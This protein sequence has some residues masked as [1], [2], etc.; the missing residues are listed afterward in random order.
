MDKVKQKKK[1]KKKKGPLGVYCYSI[2]KPVVPGFP[3]GLILD[4]IVSPSISSI[5]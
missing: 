3:H 1:K 2:L 4:I 5:L